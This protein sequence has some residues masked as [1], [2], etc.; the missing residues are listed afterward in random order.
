M[1]DGRTLLQPNLKRAPLSV[2]EPT[3]TLYEFTVDSR[4]FRFGLRDHGDY[5]VECE[6]ER[7]GSFW[8][9][10]RFD[11]WL[12]ASRPCSE[13]AIQWANEMRKLV[14]ATPN[15]EIVA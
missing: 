14:E 4:R 5:G 6:I 15:E 3:K 2:G 10:R 8:S 12:D 7:D 9:S 11:P 1:N 13:L